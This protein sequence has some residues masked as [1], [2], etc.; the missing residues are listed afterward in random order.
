MFIHGVRRI[1]VLGLLG[2]C[3]AVPAACLVAPNDYSELNSGGA[4][5]CPLPEGCTDP[6]ECR[7]MSC[8]GE[9]CEP[10][11]APADK[12]ITQ[13][14]HDCLKR[15]CDGN[16]NV[17]IVPEPSD[18]P[19]DDNNG[20]T[21]ED[22]DDATSPNAPA[23]TP[24]PGG[25]CDGLGKCTTCDDGIRNGNEVD[26]DCGGPAC[27]HCDG[28]LCGGEPLGCQSGHC[29]DGVCC[30]TPCDRKCEACVVSLTGAPSGTCAP[31]ALGKPDGNACNGLGGCGV[32]NLCACEDSAKNQNEVGV[33]CGGLCSAACGVG[34]PCEN[35]FE[36]ASG[37]CASGV[38]CATTCNGPCQQC[39]AP[40]SVG[41]CVQLA[42]LSQGACPSD[43]ACDALGVCRKKVGETCSGKGECV[44]GFCV[45]GVCCADACDGLCRSCR[46][47]VKQQG[48]D[49]LCGFIKTGG[50]PEAECTN[51]CDGMGSCAP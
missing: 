21:L 17:E 1:L 38:C 43:Q 33:D 8:V 39:D 28:E 22:C 3:G 45:D 41:M 46:A 2:V 15:R 40:G 26:I 50:D 30:S 12:I 34:T 27:P 20:C 29:V 37:A 51:S 10:I 49:G 19:E 32:N 36:C 35:S 5:A 42:P 6:A 23:G 4:G 48:A 44:S 24:C 14:Q 11:N 47:A 25:I 18:I 31:V 9:K 13:I 7:A 16:G